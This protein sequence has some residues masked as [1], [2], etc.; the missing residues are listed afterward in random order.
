M[1]KDIDPGHDLV[2]I[3]GPLFSFEGADVF[4]INLMRYQVRLLERRSHLPE[5]FPLIFI[6]HFPI[7]KFSP[8]ENRKWKIEGKFS[9]ENFRAR[10]SVG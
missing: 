1:S 9:G 7:S 6:F 2:S 5:V 8:L 4:F 3:V 10:S